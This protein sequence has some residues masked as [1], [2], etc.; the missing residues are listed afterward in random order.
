MLG[1]LYD[2]PHCSGYPGDGP[3]A[4]GHRLPIIQRCLD[5][6]CACE[7]GCLNP[8]CR[9]KSGAPKPDFPRC[10]REGERLPQR[11]T[12]RARSPGLGDPR[13]ER[14]EDE[15]SLMWKIRLRE[16][17]RQ[18]MEPAP[19][20]GAGASRRSRR[21]APSE[22]PPLGPPEPSFAGP[23]RAPG[24]KGMWYNRPTESGERVWEKV[25]G[26]PRSQ[27]SARSQASARSTGSAS[28]QEVSPSPER[29]GPTLRRALSRK[30]LEEH[31]AGLASSGQGPLA[32]RA[33]ASRRTSL[34][35]YRSEQESAEFDFTRARG[36]VGYKAAHEPEAG[37]K[38]KSL[39]TSRRR[40][41]VDL[42]RL[43]LDH[44]DV[45]G[46]RSGG[47]SASSSMRASPRGSKAPSSVRSLLSPSW[48]RSGPGPSTVGPGLSNLGP[49]PSKALGAAPSSTSETAPSG[50]RERPPTGSGARPIPAL[51]R[52]SMATVAETSGS[53]AGRSTG[54][55]ETS[56][57]TLGP[58]GQG[59][60]SVPGQGRST[61]SFETSTPTLGPSGQGRGSVPGQDQGSVPGQDRGSL[62]GQG[63]GSVSGQ[64]A[65]R[66]IRPSMGPGAGRSESHAGLPQRSARPAIPSAPE[67]SSSSEA[68]A[69][70]SGCAK[71]VGKVKK[72]CCSI[73]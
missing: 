54:S 61:G 64:A 60:G 4:D 49:G 27:G 22:A 52:Q 45:P 38:R 24:E 26:S 25:E 67:A 34:S 9:Y 10:Y 43:S 18:E 17:E 65:T 35:S 12:R 3:P 1:A 13:L 71:V 37:S 56:P 21:P 15:D 44:R 68:G 63:Q 51:A 20:S 31:E 46:P 11:P 39:E 33:A 41:S 73:S 42:S 5:P 19:A 30:N 55:F 7:I 47:L 32:R 16:A 8:E 58:S 14:G 59:R 29:R 57:P 2:P 6:A 23:V 72:E 36:G 50:S 28:S 66:M 40:L 48:T 70:R 69:S 53:G 62:P